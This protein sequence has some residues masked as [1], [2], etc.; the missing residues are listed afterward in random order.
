MNKNTPYWMWI[1]H[2]VGQ[3]SSAVPKLLDA[4]SSPEEVY[5]ADRLQLERAG[6]TG[7]PLECLCRKTI[8]TMRRT[9]ERC[10]KLGWILTPEDVGYPEQLRHLFSPPLVLYG[11]GFLPDFDTALVPSIGMVGT[12]QATEYGERAAGGMAAGLAAAGSIVISGG[13]KGIDRASH[14]GALYG[15]GRTVAVQACGLDVEYP[16]PNHDLRQR[17]VEEG[18]AIITEYLPGTPAFPNHFHVRNRLISG[19]S[20]GICVVEAPQ[21]SGALITARHA[22]EQGRDVFVVPGNITSA[23][24]FG[25]NELIKDGATLVTRPSEILH[26]YQLRCDGVLQEEEADRAQI[27]YGEYMAHGKNPQTVRRTQRVADGSRLP[28]VMPCPDSASD[29]AKEVYSRLTDTPITAE[30]LCSTTGMPAS[31]LF[32]AMTELELYGCAR[33]YPGKRYSR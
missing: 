25:S 19:L 23:K 13:A 8:D 28:I 3:G 16:L 5:A 11:R 10:E 22:R 20:W 14:E 6:I 17:I 15:G 26:D 33:S 30:E 21:R 2:A 9:A 12:R 7:K 29:V 18:G 4:F 24:S 27:A 32:S 31:K 1:Q